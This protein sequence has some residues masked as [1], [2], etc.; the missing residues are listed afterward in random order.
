[1]YFRCGECWASTWVDD[2]DAPV[3]R[4]SCESCSRTY[5]LPAAMVLRQTRKERHEQALARADSDGFDLPTAYSVVL[6]ILSL[7]QAQGHCHVPT[8]RRSRADYDRAFGPAIAAG[9][10]TVKQACERGKRVGYAREIMKHHDLPERVAFQI[11][12]NETSL[13][14]AIRRCNAAKERARQEE[15]TRKSPEPAPN[16]LPRRLVVGALCAVV[17]VSVVVTFSILRG[18]QVEGSA[19]L[20]G[21]EV[22][23][24]EARTEAPA[25]M[26]VGKPV[27]RQA[28]LVRV[29]TDD[30]GRVTKISGSDPAAILRAYCKTEPSFGILT[31][32]EITS[33]VPPYPGIRLG[34]LRDSDRIEQRYAVRIRKDRRT[35]QW[36]VGNGSQ[37]IV[38]IRAPT[39]P[40]DARRIPVH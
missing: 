5:D 34:I 9:R 33:A 4:V 40:E 23:E 2:S 6:G 8:P 39:L 31:P 22:A 20:P 32:L 13:G 30:D 29:T 14:E 27:R 11:A 21:I 35:R 16:A 19:T 37:P 1:M 12:D 36:M 38:P 18:T 7:E 25:P 15:L 24:T 28:P 10:M 26:T 3:S 17:L